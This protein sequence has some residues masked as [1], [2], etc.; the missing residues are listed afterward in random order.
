M[1]TKVIK[2]NHL[3]DKRD[4]LRSGA[5][6]S[7]QHRAQR[8]VHLQNLDIETHGFIPFAMS[9]SLFRYENLYD[10]LNS[11]ELS[12]NVGVSYGVPVVIELDGD[13]QKPVPFRDLLSRDKKLTEL[14]KMR[15]QTDQV[16]NTM[17]FRHK[18]PS[19]FNVLTYD[20]SKVKKTDHYDN[21]EDAGFSFKK[22]IFQHEYEDLDVQDKD[23]L[24]HDIVI[25]EPYFHFRT[26]H[27]YVVNKMKEGNN[28]HC[29]F[30]MGISYQN[31]IDPNKG[32]RTTKLQYFNPANCF[33][34]DLISYTS[35]RLFNPTPNMEESEY[36]D[37]AEDA[38][39]DAT[40]KPL[41]V[42]RD[43][44]D[45]AVT[46]D[47]EPAVA[48]EETAVAAEEPADPAPTM[49][50]D[51]PGQ[52]QVVT[53]NV[54]SEPQNEDKL[55]VKLRPYHDEWFVDDT[56]SD[57]IYRSHTK[58]YDL[59]EGN[60]V[61]VKHEIRGKMVNQK[62]TTTFMAVK[63]L[64]DKIHGKPDNEV[65]VIIDESGGRKK[66]KN[67]MKD[68]K[69][70]LPRNWNECG[71][72]WASLGTHQII[73]TVKLDDQEPVKIPMINKFK[74]V[75]KQELGEMVFPTVSSCKGRDGDITPI[76]D[77]DRIKDRLDFC[78]VLGERTSDYG[79]IKVL[80][81]QGISA[82]SNDDRVRVFLKMSNQVLPI[83]FDMRID[84]LDLLFD[85]P[86]DIIKDELTVK[87]YEYLAYSP[88]VQLSS[89]ETS[90]EVSFDYIDAEF[91]EKATYTYKKKKKPVACDDNDDGSND[92]GVADA[93]DG[94]GATRPSKPTDRGKKRKIENKDSGQISKAAKTDTPTACEICSITKEIAKKMDPKLT[95][96]NIKTKGH[97]VLLGA[98]H[99]CY[100][101]AMGTYK[102]GVFASLP[103]NIQAITPT[104]NIPRS[105]VEA[106]KHIWKNM[107]LNNRPGFEE[108]VN[109]VFDKE[110]AK[111]AIEAAKR[112]IEEKN[113][114]ASKKTK[115]KKSS[116]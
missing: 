113:N 10:K 20:K 12:T 49:V 1:W 31:F 24:E 16:D 45:D 99:K 15:Y 40:T 7:S 32:I 78:K 61:T 111:Q 44:V 17:A 114:R 70:L 23:I 34:E 83:G 91:N 90:E 86:Y 84:N 88:T 33:G 9:T 37:L 48:A 102:N 87:E 6:V 54:P 52:E 100:C 57:E 5:A 25:G 72:L 50:E 108:Y 29:A 109:T 69:R 63:E 26:R 62:Y 92:D 53:E 75:E 85:V 104:D 94:G 74:D 110:K 115:S 103:K 95:F 27:L 107:D 96:R 59:S 35:T 80:I 14:F 4:I 67:A 82:K 30:L 105:C 64:A 36:P 8:G 46:S 79:Q 77:L 22:A 71:K 39:T 66:I 116:A 76:T 106:Y 38:N 51:P 28:L 81:G 60:V 21:F 42:N 18:G 19:P 112:A 11:G 47:G 55:M 41:D 101:H 68:E 89:K 98:C 3:L 73:K 97:T 2:K 58:K 43:T 65:T 13:V 93:G 56:P